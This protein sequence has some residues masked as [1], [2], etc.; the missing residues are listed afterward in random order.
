MKIVMILTNGFF[1]DLRV[2]KEAKYLE[3]KGYNIEILCWDRD[4]R[5]LD[6]RIEYLN[7][8]KIIRF[9]EK[10]Q[11]GSGLK[12]I[13]QLM[14]F[15]NDCKKY[16]KSQD[17]NYDYMHCH[18]LD[19]M[20]VG[21]L[22]HKHGDKIIFDMHEFYNTGSYSKIFF[23]VKPVLKYLQHMAYKIIHV[24]DKQIENISKEDRDKLVYLPNFPEQSKFESI[25]HKYSEDIRITYA[26]Y[27]RHLIPLTNLIKAANGLEHI[28]VSIHGIGEIWNQIKDMEKKYKNVIVTG[29]FNHE[30]ISEFYS[31]SDLIYIVYNKGDKND[32]S[33]LPTKFF[34]AIISDIPMIVSK[35]SLLEDTVKK[36]DIG[37]S[38]DGTD[39]EDIKNL[40]LKIQKN[41]KLLNEKRENIKKIKNKFI[42]EE[43]VKNLDIIY[44]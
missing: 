13:F 1:P 25:E 3:K 26:G 41:P 27:V 24:N 35:N 30:E 15:K 33:A 23:I 6:K 38:V 16:L 4:N 7:N 32:E 8:I 43:I 18:D 28:K 2:Y 40:I 11:Y 20:L 10:S 12:Q 36:Y 42:W 19:G 31:E 22:L 44:Q 34:E 37:F 5:Y 21:F 39:I 9:N 29:A 17:F 14:K